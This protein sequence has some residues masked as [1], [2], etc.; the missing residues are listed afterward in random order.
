MFTVEARGGSQAVI[1][2]RLSVEFWSVACQQRTRHRT[3]RRSL[4]PI[5][6]DEFYKTRR[7]RY[8]VRGNDYPSAIGSG[9]NAGV[10]YCIGCSASQCKGNAEIAAASESLGPKMWRC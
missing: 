7:E 3:G 10:I 9:S 2:A 5:F 4:C 1:R 6:A 8:S